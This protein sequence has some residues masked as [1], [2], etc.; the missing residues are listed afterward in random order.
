[1][2]RIMN[3]V[4]MLLVNESEKLPCLPN[5]QLTKKKNQYLD[6]KWPSWQYEQCLKKF[7]PEVKE[8]VRGNGGMCDSRSPSRKERLQ[9]NMRRGSIKDYK[10]RKKE[11]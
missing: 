9:G 4:R 2:K 6:H 3:V 8:V 5:A 1:M 11:V 10:E 7:Y